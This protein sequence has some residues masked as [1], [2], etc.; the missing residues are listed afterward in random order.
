MDDRN[1]KRFENYIKIHDLDVLL[2][3]N[4]KVIKEMVIDYIV[5]L[6]DEREITNR[7]IRYLSAILRFFQKN[8][9]DFTLRITNFD[10]DLPHDDTINEDRPY[11]VEEIRQ[12]LGGQSTAID[13]RSKMIVL[14]LCSSG[15]RIGALHSL[16]YCDLTEMQYEHSLLLYRFKFMLYSR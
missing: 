16:Q 2:D 13:P 8:N 15:M 14:L 7:S 9:D 5:Y 3:F 12:I 10:I 11:N 6:R 4:Q 1:F